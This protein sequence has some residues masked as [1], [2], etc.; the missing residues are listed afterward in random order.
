MH[1]LETGFFG[2]GE[3]AWHKLG[4]VIEEDVVTAERAIEL[5]GLDWEVELVEVLVPAKVENPV[6]VDQLS[7]APKHQAVVRSTDRRVLGVVGEGWRPVQNRDAVY[8]VADAACASRPACRGCTGLPPPHLV[9]PP[10]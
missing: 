1:G 9:A 2:N 4:T 10:A 3:A 6:L 7:A 5:A 8:R